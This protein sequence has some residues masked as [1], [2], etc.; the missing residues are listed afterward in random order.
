MGTPY[1]GPFPYTNASVISGIEVSDSSFSGNVINEGTITNSGIAVSGSSID[2]RVENSGTL[3]GGIS[4]SDSTVAGGIGVSGDFSGGISIDADS[5]VTRSFFA[6]DVSSVS[7]F[8]D[9]I[10]NAGTISANTTALW[11]FEVTDFTGGI[12]NSGRFQLLV[13]P[14]SVSGTTR[15]FPAG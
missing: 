8:T 2:G 11:I 14:Q 10:T 9:G 13:D 5:K 7:S 6:V 3:T 15:P 1:S 12:T 4:I